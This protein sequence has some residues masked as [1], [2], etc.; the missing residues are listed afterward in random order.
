[1]EKGSNKMFHSFERKQHRQSRTAIPRRWSVLRGETTRYEPEALV[2]TMR[3]SQS[4]VSQ[5]E[6]TSV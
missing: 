5:A 3:T 2:A 4:T 6:V 1:M